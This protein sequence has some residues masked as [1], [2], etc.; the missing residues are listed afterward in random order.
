M[1]E[2]QLPVRND[3]ETLLDWLFTWLEYRERMEPE[4]ECARRQR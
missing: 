2:N 1:A 3:G 4:D